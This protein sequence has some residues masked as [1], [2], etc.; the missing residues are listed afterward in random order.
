[1][2][3]D[4]IVNPQTP[5]AAQIK[6]ALSLT[7][8]VAETIREAGEVPSGTLYV[9]LCDKLDHEAYTALLRTLTNA[10]L[11]RVLPSHMIQWIGQTFDKE[12]A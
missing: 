4:A 11:I 8:A 12:V 5:T 10:G 1:M 6:A 7:L 3:I 9:N 2:T